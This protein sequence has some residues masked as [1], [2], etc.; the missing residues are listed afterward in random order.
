MTPIETDIGEYLMW[1]QIHN[2]AGPPLQVG[3][4]TSPVWSAFLPNGTLTRAKTSLWRISSPTSMSSSPIASV[5]V[6]R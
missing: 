2:Y 3:G 4:A 1:M 5:T 6:F